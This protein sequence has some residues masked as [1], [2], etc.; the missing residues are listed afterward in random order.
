M[1]NFLPVAI[2][3]ILLLY[4][5]PVG[6]KNFHLWRCPIGIN[7]VYS[8]INPNGKLKRNNMQLAPLLPLE[9]TKE[10]FKTVLNPPPVFRLPLRDKDEAKRRIPLLVA[11][12]YPLKQKTSFPVVPPPK[13]HLHLESPQNHEEAQCGWTCTYEDCNYQQ[14]G[15]SDVFKAKRHVWDKHLRKNEEYCKHFDTTAVLSAPIYEQL[16]PNDRERV[17][18]FIFKFLKGQSPTETPKQI[19]NTQTLP[20]IL[21]PVLHLPQVK[22]N[23][24][25]VSPS[26]EE[27]QVEEP[28]EMEMGQMEEEE[29]E[30]NLHS[31]KKNLCCTWKGCDYIQQ[32]KDIWKAKR[33]I[34]DK[35]LRTSDLYE[36][37]CH[38]SY[39][40]SYG[41]LN[42]EEKKVL[43][44][45]LLK[46]VG[47]KVS[48]QIRG[49]S[50]KKRVSLKT[51]NLPL[52]SKPKREKRVSGEK[53]PRSP[54]SPKRSREEE[55][56]SNKKRRVVTR[57]KTESIK[58][59]SK[60]T[61]LP[62]FRERPEVVPQEDFEKFGTLVWNP[63]M[64]SEED[65]LELKKF[66]ASKM[67]FT[68]VDFVRVYDIF[69]LNGYNLEKTKDI[70]SSNLLSIQKLKHKNDDNFDSSDFSSDLIQLK[71][72][73]NDDVEILYT[74]ES[75]CF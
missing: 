56:S 39:P 2:L 75:S 4:W 64:T 44:S 71:K 23:I 69:M 18:G 52:I 30:T 74:T 31:E 8:N 67:N 49:F 48:S 7:S 66:C 70:I 54:R 58:V 55:S 26:R 27:I 57:S 34:W 22:E 6:T 21:P 5:T 14:K 15:R 46:Y 50:P 72:L 42:Q 45:N 35:H 3:I 25:P 65:V 63:S 51:N 19:T 33:H 32:E 16:S 40:P 12:P 11:N 61:V 38:K 1:R 36:T 9:Q 47:E 17:K 43:D 10:Y 41:K 24:S 53:S 60:H 37:L 73:L 62:E 68:S 13:K 59:Q 20:T 29:E 28:Q